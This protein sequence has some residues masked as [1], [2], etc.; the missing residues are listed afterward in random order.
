[1]KLLLDQNLSFR[2][3]ALLEADFPGTTHL[4]VIGM[5]RASD[6]L[7]WDYAALHGFAVLTKDNDFHHRSLLLGA[8]PKIVHLRIGNLST[9]SIHGILKNKGTVITNFLQ[10]TDE[11]LLILE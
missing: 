3:V 5:S 6:E 4:Q 2:L 1:M 11:S 7:I 10:N 9:K 8:P